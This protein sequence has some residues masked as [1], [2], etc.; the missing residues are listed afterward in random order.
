M[1]TAFPVMACLGGHRLQVGQVWVGVLPLSLNWVCL[2]R[3]FRLYELE[4][5]HKQNKDGQTSWESYGTA[6]PG[7]HPAQG[8]ACSRSGL[9]LTTAISISCMDKA[10]RKL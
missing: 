3:L 8:L 10:E 6:F 9:M 1:W 4:V 5:S 7:K 2:G